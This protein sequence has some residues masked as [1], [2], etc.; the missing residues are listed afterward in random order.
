MRKH[1]TKCKGERMESQ[2]DFLLMLKDKIVMRINFNTGKFDIEEE[3]Y[4]PWE[5]RGRIREK[6]PEKEMYTKYDLTQIRVRDTHNTEVIINWLS[7]RVLP[8]SRDNAKKIYSLFRFEQVQ[9]ERDKAKIAILCRAVSL[10]DNY[11]IKL[12][13]D[14]KTWDDVDL[15]KNS[16]SDVVAQVSLNGSGLSIQGIPHTPELT[17]QGAYAKAWF[18][19]EDGVLW[20]YKRGHNGTTE[21]KIEVMVSDLLDNCNVEHVHYESGESN[22]TYICKCPCITTD[23]LSIMPGMDFITWC[24][25][26]EVNWFEELLKIDAQ[27]IYKMCIVD[28]LI[29]NRDRHGLN[30]GLFYRCDNMD[31]LGCHPL[32]DHNNA[33]DIEYMK[34]ENAPYQFGKE[35]WTVKEAALWASKKIDFYFYKKFEQKDFITER[36]YKSF[37]KRAEQLDIQVKSSGL[38]ALSSLGKE[39]K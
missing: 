33:F 10:Q 2:K 25:V 29:S 14:N 3:D 35:G 12:E 7:H 36:Q 32:L 39:G 15:R 1:L 23:E 17:G 5:I 18:R 4:L 30:W 37:M 21:S 9:G 6:Y 11:W 16:L 34:D 24:N 38:S 28:Y 19:E 22:G 27:S 13:D 31:I 8:I 20:L 26:R